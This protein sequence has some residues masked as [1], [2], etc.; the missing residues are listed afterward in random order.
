MEFIEA[1]LLL[2]VA[3]RIGGELA[4]RAGQPAMMGELAAGVL[5]GPSVLNLLAITPSIKTLA[6]LGVLLLVFHAGLE[7]DFRTVRQAVSGRGAWVGISAFLTPLAMGLALG[8]LVDFDH[9]RALFLGLCIAITALPVS[10][11]LLMDLGTLRSEVGQRIIGAGVMN[12]VAALLVLGIILD[13]QTTDGN[14]GQLATAVGRSLWKAV[15]FIGT[16]VLMARLVRYSAGHLPLGKRLLG[17]LLAKVKIKEAMF[18]IVLVFVLTFAAFSDIIGLHFIVGAFFGSVIVGQELV[19]RTNFEVLQ[20]IA[21]SM[22]TAFLGPIFFATIGLELQLASLSNWPLLLAVLLTA[23][24]GKLLGGFWG[25][26][27]AGMDQAS[28]W[29]V[30]AGVNGRGIMELVIANIALANGFISRELFSIL[31]TMG[32]VTTFMT[33]FLMR[34]ALTA[35]N[36]PP[37]GSE[38][39]SE[40]AEPQ[41]VPGEGHSQYNSLNDPPVANP[42][43]FLAIEGQPLTITGAQLTANDT[44]P[45]GD[46]LTVT[47]VIA[48]EQTYGM[49]SLAYGRIVYQPQPGFTGAAVFGYVLSDGR[50][51]TALGSV[52]VTVVPRTTFRHRMGAL[53]RRLRWP[54]RHSSTASRRR[55]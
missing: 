34:R 48:E 36:L 39:A 15:L 4:E 10:I 17:M 11:R 20:K 54:R 25:G 28:S 18:G 43:R 26:R 29:A 8:W 47:G 2:L 52:T 44:D 40:A 23:V 41:G 22:T 1:I 24:A 6:D 45:D 9:L 55:E 3:V 27:L 7:M 53:A 12:D 35:K 31:V 42:D 46:S 37:T 13:L 38:T 21:S 32:G 5:L 50:G 51:G 14:W 49:V 33:P 16:V 30:G 19:G